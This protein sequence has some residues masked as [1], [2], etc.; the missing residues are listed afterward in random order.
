VSRKHWI[1]V[2]GLAAGLVLLTFLGWRFFVRPLADDVAAAVD[3][4]QA[5]TKQLQT[6]RDTAAQFAKFKAQASAM[7]R[8]LDF[9]ESRMDGDLDTAS[10]LGLMDDLG[11]PLDLQEW[12]VTAK[13]QSAPGRG[14]RASALGSYEVTVSFQSDF[15][16]VGRFL[17]ACVGQRRIIVPEGISLRSYTDPNGLYDDTLSATITLAVYGGKPAA[18]SWR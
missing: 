10:V 4:K 6:A 14:S 8:E 12:N 7:D 3:Q 2:G 5:L 13:Q 16:S 17:N 1:T 9:Y 11:R 15:E 18:P